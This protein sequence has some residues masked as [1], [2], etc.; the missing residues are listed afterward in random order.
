[1]IGLGAGML[2]SLGLH[3]LFGSRWGEG[4]ALDRTDLIAA[5]SGAGATLG[6]AALIK[7]RAL[8]SKQPPVNLHAHPHYQAPPTFRPRFQMPR[9]YILWS[10]VGAL[11]GV[12][13]N[14]IR[15]ES[16]KPSEIPPVA[17]YE[18]DAQNANANKW[19][20]EAPTTTA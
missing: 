3:A 9:R 16:N 12:M 14:S 2:T 8:L 13:V 18:G 19:G 7:N 11:G 5:I 20:D 15:I 17:G 10:V 1:M 4:R 6:T